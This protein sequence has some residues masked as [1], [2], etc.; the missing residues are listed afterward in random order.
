MQSHRASLAYIHP[1][2]ISNCRQTVGAGFSKVVSK[3]YLLNSFAEGMAG[4]P[5]HRPEAWTY[6]LSGGDADGVVAS[7]AGQISRW[8]R[9]K[10]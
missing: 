2:F 4:D 8:R 1:D 10:R 7:E 5:Y 3:Y 6:L 9:S